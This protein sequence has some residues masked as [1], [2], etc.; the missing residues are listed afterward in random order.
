MG[1]LN[2]LAPD[3]AGAL[4][5]GG[6]MP[7]RQR[8]KIAVEIIVL[9]VRVRW[10]VLRRELPEVVEHL[11]GDGVDRLPPDRARRL[12]LRLGRPVLRTLSPLPWD[13][14][15]LMRSLVLLSM[16]ARRGVACRLV[17]GVRSDGKFSAH[18]WI[19]HDDQPLM[20]THG[21]EPLTTI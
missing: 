17:I 12:G 10:L 7:A 16:L 1:L 13:S 4:V 2:L 15:C 14:R 20:P 8:L 19:E 5:R 21:H 18:A 3:D 6:P 9:Y 11:R